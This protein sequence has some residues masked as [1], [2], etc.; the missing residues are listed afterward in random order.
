MKKN[1]PQATIKNHKIHFN[2][3]LVCKE[4]CFVPFHLSLYESFH[5]ITVTGNESRT[6]LIAETQ[7]LHSIPL[8]FSFVYKIYAQA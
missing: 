6:M 1:H 2:K 4:H 5:F 8:I 3:S 7:F